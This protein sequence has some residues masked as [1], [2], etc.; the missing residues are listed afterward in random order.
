[1][2][3]RESEIEISRLTVATAADFL[4]DYEKELSESGAEGDYTQEI[5]DVV[6][7][8]DRALEMKE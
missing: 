2:S 1:M 5:Q 8:L 7:A 4:R 3:D 6:E